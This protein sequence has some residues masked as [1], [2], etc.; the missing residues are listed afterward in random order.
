MNRSAY[1]ILVHKSEIPDI[2]VNMI[3]EFRD[4]VFFEDNFPYK[5]ETDKT[6]GKR[7]HEMTFRD[8]NPEEPIV[9]AEIESRRS[10]RSRISKSFGLD[11]ITYAIESEH[12]T[13]KEAMSILEVQ[14]WKE[15]IDSEIESILSN[16]T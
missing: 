6:S 16:H 5:R 1:R 13:F 15:V 14:M 2:H 9:N 7:T 8:E 12:Q 10:Q 4:A 3:I 11:F